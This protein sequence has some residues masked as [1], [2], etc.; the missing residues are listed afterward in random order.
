MRAWISCLF[1]LPVSTFG[2]ASPTLAATA[3]T[4]HSARATVTEAGATGQ[5]DKR[6]NRI[7]D[8]A[9]VAAANNQS[10]TCCQV[11]PAVIHR[12]A[13]LIDPAVA[14]YLPAIR[15]NARIQPF[16]RLILFPFHV[17]W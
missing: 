8:K 3:K 1:I 2:V 15:G 17:F 14:A 13:A 5:H 9:I 6:C 16:Y 4:A 10:D 11:E 12:S 7:E